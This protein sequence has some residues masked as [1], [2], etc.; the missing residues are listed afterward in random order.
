MVANGTVI[1]KRR[2]WT[3]QIDTVVIANRGYGTRSPLPGQTFCPDQS[4]AS[5]YDI[6]DAHQAAWSYLD[7][8]PEAGGSPG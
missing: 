2:R 4:L 6:A 5:Y 3:C 7:A 1:G 8:W